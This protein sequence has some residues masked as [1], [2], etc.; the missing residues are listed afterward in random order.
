MQDTEKVVREKKAVV[1]FSGHVARSLLKLGYTIIDVK[2]DNN[3]PL[4]SVFVFR[5]EGNIIK[6]MKKLTTKVI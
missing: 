1:V 4:K 6:D 5:I 3:V 2:Q